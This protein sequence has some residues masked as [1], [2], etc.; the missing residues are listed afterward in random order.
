MKKLIITLLSA[1]A[2]VSAS[3]ETP[4]WLRDAAISPDGKTVAFTYKG[5]IFTVPVSG[6]K[7]RQITSNSAYDSRPLWTP[8]GDRIVFNSARE[9]STDIFICDAAGGNVRRLTTHSGTETPLGFN[10]EGLLLFTSN[11]QPSQDA[12]QGPFQTQLYSL[13]INRDNAR[14]SMVYSLQLRALSFNAD[15]DML[16]EDKKGYE[17]PLRK[18]ERSSGTSDIWLVSDGKFS[19][20]TDFNGH[21]LNPVWAPDG[22]K[23]YYISE[24]DGTLN[25]YSSSTAGGNKKQLTSFT[26]HPVRSLSAASDGTLAFSWDGELYTLT[27]G[28]APR[29]ID[30]EIIGDDY[31]S[32]VVKNVRRSGA[33]TMAVSPSGDEVA[34]VIRGDIYVTSTKYKTTKRITDTPAQER[35]VEFSPDG[36]TLVYDSDRDGVW[37]LFTARIANDDE[38]QFAYASDIIEEPLYSCATSAQQPVFSPDGKKVAFLEDRTALRIIDLDS[39]KVN[40]ALSGDY[41]YSYTDG[42]ITFEWSP[43]SRWLLA[44]YIGVGG[45]NNSDIALVRAD[46]SEVI[47]LTESGYSDGNPKWALGGKALTYSTGRYGMRSHGSWG[48]TSDIILMVL[49]GEAWDNFNMTEEEAD[50]AEKAK[51]DKKDAEN[52]DKASK[53]D[54]K[55]KGK[56]DEADK[57]DAE[58]LAFDLANRKYRMRRLTSA[59]SSLGD[60][61]LSPKGDKLYYSAAATEGGRNLLVHDL[62]KGETKVLLKGISGGFSADKDGKNLFVISG[63]GMKKIDLASADSKPIEFEAPYDRKPSKEREYIYDHMWK[64]VKDKFYDADLHGV[65][66]QYYGDHYRRFLPHINNNYDFATLLSEILG[67]LNASHTGGRYYADGAQMPTADLGAFFDPAYDGDGLRI[68]EIM[69]RGPLSPSKFGLKPGDIIMAIDG[70]AIEAGKD[71]YPL[72]EG[73][74]GKKTALTVMRAGGKTDRIEVTPVGSV[75]DLLYTRWVERNQAMVDSLSGGRIGYVHVSGMDSPSFRTVFDEMLGKYRNREAIIVDTR[76]NGGGW[77]HNDLAVLLGGKEYVRFVPR[78]Q[79]IGSEPFTQWT[80]PSVMLVNES[81]YSDAHGS[82]FV[83]Q[84]LGLGDVVGAPVPGTMTAVWWENQIDPSLIFGIPQVTSVDMNGNVL[85]NRQLNPDVEIYNR[86]DDIMHGIDDQIAGSVRTLLQKLNKNK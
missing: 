78:G 4:L 81:N 54:K 21:D 52:D 27:E 55:K 19:K 74:A 34:F 14:P 33:T 48:N 35:C 51:D 13:D 44:D 82:P 86:P 84:T 73:K 49:D 22:K 60:Y 37:Q 40:T 58:P 17:D 25:V 85:E 8:A 64:Q 38:K 23:F 41:N 31:D 66:W 36:R 47:D 20:L 6:G 5:D 59:S 57:K 75:R 83:Y 26:K 30:I 65:D 7:A 3:A 42:D 80:K 71:Y 50:L 45:W 62:K 69:P 43:D 39:K 46:G 18:H 2:A 32:D 29:K 72:L 1:A 9:G 28:S 24:E 67:E 79:Y 15:G 11:I 68:A 56:N 53:K 61:Y 77:L 70:L 76:W 63:G 16:Y 12:I 10:P